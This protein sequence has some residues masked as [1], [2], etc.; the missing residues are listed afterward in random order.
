MIN[1]RINDRKV[2]NIRKLVNSQ[3]EN[4]EFSYAS[5]Q[6]AQSSQSE[7]SKIE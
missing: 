1:T 5:N 6:P 3:K 2:G 7:N 4:D